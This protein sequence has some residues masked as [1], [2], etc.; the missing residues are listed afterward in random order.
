[1]KDR[2][3]IFT[4]I[5]GLDGCRRLSSTFYARLPNDPVL[6]KFFP[7]MPHCAVES[8]AQCIA[9][10]LGGPAEYSRMRPWI[11]LTEAHAR[12]RIGDA[13]AKAWL[14]NMNE[15]IDEAGIVGDI[16]H[17]LRAFFGDAITQ[18]INHD[19]AAWYF[20]GDDWSDLTVTHIWQTQKYIDTV[21][22][23][24]RAGE[25]DDALFLAGSTVKNL[26]DDRGALANLLAEIGSTNAPTAVDFATTIVD[27]DRELLSELY[28]YG[29]M[30]HHAASTTASDFVDRLLSLGANPNLGDKF[31]HTPLYSTCNGAGDVTIARAL[32][33]AGADV[34]AQDYV[35]RCAP[36]HMAARRGHVDVAAVLIESGANVEVRDINGQTPLRRAVNCGKPDVA[37]ILLAGGANVDAVDKRGVS[38]RQAAAKRRGRG[39]ST[40]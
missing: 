30:L 3:T 4:E 20:G 29:S 11:S 25:I 21:I 7:K 31:G 24:L 10:L 38:A 27:G 12:F 13:E 18:F 1:M 40:D 14:G 15:A 37:T 26:D 16:R 19:R 36:L 17:L 8:L 6:K 28:Y 35:K 33:A 9:Q 34:D 2:P 23:R 32:I 5:G 22:G 39:L